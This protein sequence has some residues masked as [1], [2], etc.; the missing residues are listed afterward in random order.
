MA[1]VPQGR[2]SVGDG[3][4]ELL[5]V[6]VVIAAV[7]PLLLVVEFA[8]CA[9]SCPGSMGN[10]A[11]AAVK[12]E[13]GPPPVDCVAPRRPDVLLVHALRL[14]SAGGEELDVVRH[15]GQLSDIGEGAHFRE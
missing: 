2:T 11:P 1:R 10:E 5:R 12:Q 4:I 14:H 7:P 8:T 6:V 9:A 13:A 3:S 15:E